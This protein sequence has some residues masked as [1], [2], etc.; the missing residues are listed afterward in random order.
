MFACFTGLRVSDLRT[1]TWGMIERNPPQIIKKQKKTKNPV[2]IPLNKS[3]AG[4]IFDGGEHLPDEFVFSL[5]DGERNDKSYRIL[6]EWAEKAGVAKRIG[7]HTA[8]RTFATL[9][10]GGGADA[11]TVARLLGHTGLSQV[12]KYA[13]ATDEMRRKAVDALPEI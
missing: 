13:K 9:A 12:M 10:L 3:A 7:W 5:G 6:N 4:L 1:L 11:V 2:Y 8:R